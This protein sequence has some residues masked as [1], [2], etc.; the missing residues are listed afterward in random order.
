MIQT[1][2]IE[3]PAFLASAL[4]NDDTSGFT[5]EDEEI[6]ADFLRMVTRAYGDTA[7][8]ADV[9]EETFFARHYG[10]GHDMATYIV[11]YDV[12]AEEDQ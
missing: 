5:S 3:G 9:S 6:L 12:D 11:V 4:I 1:D 2:T 10:I 7:R 8:V